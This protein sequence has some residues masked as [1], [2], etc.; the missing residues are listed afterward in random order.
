MKTYDQRKYELIMRNLESELTRIFGQ[1]NIV[2]FVTRPNINI[3]MDV[4]GFGQYDNANES[5]EFHLDLFDGSYE[6]SEIKELLKHLLAIHIESQN[7]AALEDAQNIIWVSFWARNSDFVFNPKMPTLRTLDEA[8]NPLSEKIEKLLRLAQSDNENE[9]HLALQKAQEL[10]NKESTFSGKFSLSKAVHTLPIR[11][12]KKKLTEDC[13]YLGAILKEYF[14]VEVVYGWEWNFEKNIHHKIMELSGKPSDLLIA[15]HVYFYLKN[16]F[17][18]LWRKFRSQTKTRGVYDTIASKRAYYAGL[19]KG[20]ASTL[21]ASKKA[22]EEAR[23]ASGD[24]DQ[25]INQLMVLKQDQLIEYMTQKYPG[26][27]TRKPV[28]RKVD[29]EKMISGMRDGKNITIKPGIKRG[30]KE[31]LYLS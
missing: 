22:S 29:R 23:N 31:A 17:E 3:H 27:K 15:E 13:E 1:Y 8:C 4:N 6:W 20:F 26:I 10:M 14:N 5:L 16:T 9:A 30:Q 7:K 25:G 28:Y 18:S 21:E 12:K 11:L 2:S 19:F 24:I